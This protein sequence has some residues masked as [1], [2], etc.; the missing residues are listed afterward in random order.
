MISILLTFTALGVYLMA[1]LGFWRRILSTP[2]DRRPGSIRKIPV[3]LG[4]MAAILHTGLLWPSMIH[5]G[6]LDLSLGYVFSL[7]C[8]MTVLVYLFAALTG[9]VVNLGLFVMPVGLLG[10]VVGKFLPGSH[11]LVSDMHQV[12]WWHMGLAL[13]AFGFLC[14][15]AAQAVLLFIQD[16]HLHSHRPGSLLPALAPIQTMERNLFRLI[17]IGVVLLTANLV[18]G[19]GFQWVEGGRPLEF[20]HHILLSIIAWSAFVALLVGHKIYGWRGAVAARWTMAAFGI[21]LLAYFGSRFVS[22][23]ILS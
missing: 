19:M 5:D 1:G 11:Y 20:N 4:W 8:L 6:A 2:A 16:R 3:L 9:N 21:L 23:I 12:Q 22:T 17:L 18:T 13:L 15:A 14:I 7:V 10:F